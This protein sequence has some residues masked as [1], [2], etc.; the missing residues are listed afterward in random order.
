M[1]PLLCSRV[2]APTIACALCLSSGV[3]LAATPE[4]RLGRSEQSIIYGADDRREVYEVEN[5]ELRRRAEL[6]TVSFVYRQSLVY[7]ED[8]SVSIEAPAYDQL[9]GL[10][11]DEPFLDQ[12]AAAWCTGVL[13]DDDLVLT[14][15]HCLGINPLQV[16]ATCKRMAIAF[17]YHYESPGVFPGLTADDIFG[18]RSVVA[19][20]QSNEDLQLPDFAIVQL[21]KSAVPRHESTAVRLSQVERGE[22]VAVITHGAGLPSKVDEGATVQDTRRYTEYFSAD[23]DTFEGASGSPVFDADSALIGV[24]TRGAGDWEDGP[25]CR[26]SVHTTVGAEDHQVVTSPIEYLCGLQ[27]PSERLCGISPTCGDEVC[28]LTEDNDSCP[29]DCKVQ[30]CGDDICEGEE[31]LSC[32]LDCDPFAD[33]PHDWLCPPE[34]YAAADGCD[35]D[36][37]A[38]DPDCVDPEQEVLWCA[39]GTACLPTGECDTSPQPKLFVTDSGCAWVKGPGRSQG[40]LPLFSLGLLAAA[41]GAA[42]RRRLRSE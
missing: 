25:V 29:V 34:Y 27:W 28:S 37:G 31:P 9:Y 39:E 1:V 17:G 21:D 7:S 16:E 12:P 22:A 15:G 2:S 41:L 42:R 32:D 38:V 19:W 14:A 33:I 30:R 35:C 3:S 24:H 11:P 26:S 13:I 4:A 8:S 5:A 18:C 36:C 6:S 23:T 10:C 20:T 40:E